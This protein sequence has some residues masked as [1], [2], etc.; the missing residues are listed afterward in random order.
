M[1][2]LIL[3]VALGFA[4]TY[5]GTPYAMRYLMDSGIYG[6]D[7]QKHEKPKIPSSGGVVVFFGFMVSVTFYLGALS[8]TSPGNTMIPELL[9][10]LASVSII[11][12]IGFI[13]D[14]HIDIEEYAAE[15]LGMKKADDKET[16]KETDQGRKFFFMDILPEK[17]SE[18]HRK[19]LDQLP[20]MLFVLPAVFPL[21]AVRAGSWTMHFPVI[22]TVNWGL[23]YPFVLLPLGLLFVSNVVNM[24]A[25]TNGLSGAMSAVAAFFLGLFTFINGSVEASIIAFSLFGALL[26]FLRYNFYPASILPGD[27]MTYLAGAALFSTI[28]IGDVEKFGVFIFTPWLIEFMLKLRSGFNAHSWGIIQENGKLEPQYEKTYSLTHPLMRRG[29]TEKQI[30]LTLAGTETLIC[31]TGI[32]LFST[33]L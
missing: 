12:L 17:D 27:S 22:G 19:G 20:K 30:T 4:L 5:A 29:L 28:V 26:A 10:A 33:V 21:M 3:A 18:V 1:I 9:A 25:G 11:S 15:E 31:I 24:L 23:I 32:I 6:K 8:F 14:I 13:D 2:E 7:Q 16:N